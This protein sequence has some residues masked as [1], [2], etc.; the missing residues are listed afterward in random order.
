MSHSTHRVNYPNNQT[1]EV[2][3]WNAGRPQFSINLRQGRLTQWNKSK[4]RELVSPIACW[5]GPLFE[6][7]GGCS[8]YPCRC[9]NH[10][11]SPKGKAGYQIKKGVSRMHR[12][13]VVQGE[14][15]NRLWVLE[16][17]L[18]EGLFL[19]ISVHWRFSFGTMGWI[20]PS[21]CLRPRPTM[22]PDVTELAMKDMSISLMTPL[23]SR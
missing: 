13:V 11:T 10:A 8:T 12:S 1:A 7:V 18:S 5:P 15:W 22:T 3:S 2:Y 19:S 23:L 9:Y 4:N 20:A 21:I 16:Q 17:I 6:R 14:Y